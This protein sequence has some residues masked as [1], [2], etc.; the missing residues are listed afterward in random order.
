MRVCGELGRKILGGKHKSVYRGW[1]PGDSCLFHH[2]N[3]DA[4]KTIDSRFE[5]FAGMKPT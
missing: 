3:E 5:T 2:K 4:V 1:V